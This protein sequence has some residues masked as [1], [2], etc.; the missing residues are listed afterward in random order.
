VVAGQEVD[1]HGGAAQDIDGPT[2]GPV[3][4]E[5]VVEDVTGDDDGT[6][7]PLGGEGEQSFDDGQP[8]LAVPGPGLVAEEPAV[9]AQLPV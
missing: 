3:V 6:A 2:P 7:V 9:H 1:R 5:V 4:D 8:R